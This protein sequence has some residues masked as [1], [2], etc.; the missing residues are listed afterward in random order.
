MITLVLG[1]T[2]SGKSEIAE[3]IAVDAAPR[4]TYMATGVAT[5]DDMAAIGED[6]VGGGPP[7]R[8]DLGKHTDG[9]SSTNRQGGS[10]QPDG[11]IDHLGVSCGDHQEQRGDRGERRDREA[12]ERGR[13]RRRAK[14]RQLG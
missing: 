2:R 3:Q 13:D 1:G 14:T 8:H 9:R 7:V 4:V 5:D 11:D 12:E 6:A 10:I